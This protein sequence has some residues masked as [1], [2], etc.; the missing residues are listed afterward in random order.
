MKGEKD[1][2]DEEVDRSQPTNQVQ[3]WHLVIIMRMPHFPMQTF[4]AAN[5]EKINEEFDQMFKQNQS[6]ME[7]LTVRWQ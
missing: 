2:S 3:Q 1:D 4:N 6:Q 7:T 5:Y